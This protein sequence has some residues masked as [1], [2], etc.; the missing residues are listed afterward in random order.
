MF[1]VWFPVNP[2][3]MLVAHKNNNSQSIMLTYSIGHLTRTVLDHMCHHV[4]NDTKMLSEHKHGSQC[5]SHRG[6]VIF[7]FCCILC[8]S[9]AAA[10][11]MSVES[12]QND[13]FVLSWSSAPEVVH[14][15]LSGR[16]SSF[17]THICFIQCIVSTGV[18]KV[19]VLTFTVSDLGGW[20]NELRLIFL[21]GTPLVPNGEFF[22][23]LLEMCFFCF[24]F[25][26]ITI[27]Y[28]ILWQNQTSIILQLISFPFIEEWHCRLWRHKWSV[29]CTAYFNWHSFT[30]K[31]TQV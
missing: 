30:Q 27:I 18:T 1:T 10:L 4:T 8:Q 16:L 22:W 7:I 28:C 20:K 9:N 13:T 23:L 21:F 17:G 12:E 11:H 3:S 19:L 29:L 31:C 2:T 24:I 15:M 25:Q 5:P 6:S 14:Y 26:V